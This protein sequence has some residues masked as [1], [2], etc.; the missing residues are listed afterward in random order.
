MSS[1]QLEID[2]EPPDKF[3]QLDSVCHEH[4]VFT[5]LW[6]ICGEWSVYG[7]NWIHGDFNQ[8][9]TAELKRNIT[10]DPS[11]KLAA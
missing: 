6:K 11:N 5:T 9:N 3:L 10:M 8:V 4:K 2:I 7:E 1:K